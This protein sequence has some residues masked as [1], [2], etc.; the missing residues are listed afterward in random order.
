MSRGSER[1]CFPLSLKSVY[2]PEQ[3]HLPPD[4]IRQVYHVVLIT[5]FVRQTA[6]PVP[7]LQPLLGLSGVVQCQSIISKAPASHV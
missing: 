7:E 5:V 3:I 2:F 6:A 4:L 1:D